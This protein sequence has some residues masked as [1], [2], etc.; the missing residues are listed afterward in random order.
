MLEAS[1][2]YCSRA[3]AVLV[4][5]LMLVGWSANV[6]ASSAQ[7]APRTP[8]ETVREFYKALR[9]K[10]FR[11]AFA[12]SIYKP[13]IDGLS[14]EEFEEL[15]P[16]FEKMAGAVPEN[17]EFNGEQT[18]GDTATVFVN[19]PGADAADQAEPVTLQR[20]GGV[21]IV[22]DKANQEIVR[23]S[24]KDFFFNARIDTHHNEVNDMLK[25]ISLAELL[26]NSQHNG[27]F[28]DLPTLVKTGLLPKDI[29]SSE[30][31][32]YHFHLALAQDSKSFTAGA[33]PVRYGR[34]GRL[35]FYMDNRAVRSADN[36]GKPL[37]SSSDKK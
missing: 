25:R 17:I 7:A 6:A 9:E 20:V 21:W 13:A 23:K 14:A 30:S 22:G 4:I 31:T 34:T 11:E 36:G 12:M 24:G 27:L 16:D 18:S 35:S 8:T 3:L 19:V 5:S 29:E 1:T 32:G 26:Y 37:S 15:R 10:R 33:E 2:V 28:A